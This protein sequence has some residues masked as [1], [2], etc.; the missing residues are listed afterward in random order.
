MLD[1]QGKSSEEIER[2]STHR[3]ESLRTYVTLGKNNLPYV[4]RVHEGTGNGPH[5]LQQVWSFFIFVEC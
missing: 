1:G 5:V 4:Y 2:T 3:R